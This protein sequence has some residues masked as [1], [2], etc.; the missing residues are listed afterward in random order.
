[1]SRAAL[2]ADMEADWQAEAEVCGWGVTAEGGQSSDVLMSAT[3][4]IVTDA[5]EGQRHDDREAMAGESY[6]K[7]QRAALSWGVAGCPSTVCKEDA[8]DN[9]TPGQHRKNLTEFTQFLIIWV[10]LSIG[11][12]KALQSPLRYYSAGDGRVFHRQSEEALGSAVL[13][14]LA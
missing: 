5:G 11:R 2:P 14:S 9:R 13:Y 4:P 10:N 1:M 8:L 7:Y 6:R 3:V 12:R